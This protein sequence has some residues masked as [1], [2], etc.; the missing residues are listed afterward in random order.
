MTSSISLQGLFDKLIAGEASPALFW[1]ALGFYVVARKAEL[2][3]LNEVDVDN[4]LK[5]IA[6]AQAAQQ[7]QTGDQS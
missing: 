7:N 4:A 6:Q 3:I 2:G 5:A 1:N